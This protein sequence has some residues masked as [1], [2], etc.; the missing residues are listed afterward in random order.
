[1]GL[2]IN[3]IK[4][5]LLLNLMSITESSPFVGSIY[6][7]RNN[8]LA[9]EE[10][11]I[12]EDIAELNYNEFRNK[13]CQS[14]KNIIMARLFRCFEDDEEEKSEE[15]NQFMRGFLRLDRLVG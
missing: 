12:Q 1:M 8:N 2:P 13:I 3:I 15:L 7:L 10:N 11:P 4:I 14:A 6:K 5:V 9:P